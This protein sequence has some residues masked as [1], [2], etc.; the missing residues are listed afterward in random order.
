MSM[1]SVAQFAFFRQTKKNI[2]RPFFYFLSS[3][4]I[5]LANYYAGLFHREACLAG[6]L[7][8]AAVIFFFAMFS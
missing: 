2:V 7:V 1:G 3:L 4:G 8:F 5:F 6:V